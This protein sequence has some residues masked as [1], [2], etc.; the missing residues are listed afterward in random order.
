MNDRPNRDAPQDRPH[1][2]DPDGAAPPASDA[3]SEEA[4]PKR[5]KH[6]PLKSVKSLER[7]RT[8]VEEAARE[9]ARLRE[10]NRRL[11]RRI[12]ELEGRPAGRSIGFEEDP[13]A[14]ARKIKGFI[15]T[16]DQYLETEEDEH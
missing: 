12:E 13:E 1:R 15:R 6:V 3:P 14:L 7:L 8:R 10:E 16:I 4:A 11:T 2:R 5:K 9:L